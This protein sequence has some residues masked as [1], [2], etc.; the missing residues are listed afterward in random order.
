MLGNIKQEWGSAKEPL[1][2]QE[3]VRLMEKLNILIMRLI[4]AEMSS[5]K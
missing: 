5:K 4:T 1:Q 2:L 3:A